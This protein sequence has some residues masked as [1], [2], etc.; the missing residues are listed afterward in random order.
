MLHGDTNTAWALYDELLEKGLN[1][2]PETWCVLFTR[3]EMSEGDAHEA[4]HH[5]RLLGILLYMRNNQIY[6]NKMVASGI[7][8]W[9]E[10][11]VCR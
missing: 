5:Q 6:P 1:P 11:Y 10:R 3:A 4:E 8:T 7:K 2:H 9:F